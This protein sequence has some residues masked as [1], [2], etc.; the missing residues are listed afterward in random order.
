Q[1]LVFHDLVNLTF[2]PPAKF[3]RRYADAAAL[4]RNAVER[5]REDVEH[6][7][8]PSDKESYHLPAPARK[9]VIEMPDDADAVVNSDARQDLDEFGAA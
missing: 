4:F 6:R 7:A 3:V 9:T 2:A 5:Y 1:I 8:F